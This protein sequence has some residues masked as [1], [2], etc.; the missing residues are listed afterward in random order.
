MLLVQNFGSDSERKTKYPMMQPF[1][2][3]PGYI[4]TEH[5]QAAAA[6]RKCG[7]ADNSN[8]ARGSRQASRP[9]KIT[10]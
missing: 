9:P 3:H 5:F 8:D 2:L 7:Y 1:W 4:F 10:N 6:K